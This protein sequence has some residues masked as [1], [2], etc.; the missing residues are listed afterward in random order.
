MAKT[1]YDWNREAKDL[2]T[3]A[4][5]IS[6]LDIAKLC[7]KGPMEEL[8]QTKHLQPAMTTAVL[9]CFAG[10]EYYDVIPSYV[11]GHSLGEYA[12]LVAADVIDTES[13]FKLVSLRG[14]LMDEQAQKN[15]GAMT[16][17]MKISKERAEELVKGISESK[18]LLIANYNSPN[19]L[20]ASGSVEAIEELEAALKADRARGVR[21]N[22]SGAWHSPLMNDAVAPL[23][24]AIE[25]I[26][27]NDAKMPIALNVTGGLES[28][29]ATIKSAMKKQMISSV[30]WY[31][32]IHEIWK[33][34]IRNYIE[35]G[36]KGVLTRMMKS[37]SPDPSAMTNAIID[38]VTAL[39]AFM[40]DDEEY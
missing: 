29:G 7:F 22:V 36:P 18:P 32:G 21:L 12:A 40:Q 2:F 11:A 15:P 33:E 28:D 35:P 17:M 9:A 8:T 20:V 38:T 5:D 6:G 1:F 34:G 3:E 23:E 31:Q 14:K 25:A 4:S 13:C 24:E 30:L 16:A 10:L 26:E 19:Q 27:F 37:I 39:E